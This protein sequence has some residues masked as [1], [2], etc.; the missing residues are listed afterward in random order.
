MI[1]EYDVMTDS[2]VEEEDGRVGPHTHLD[3]L[4][5][6]FFTSTLFLTDVALGL[7][8]LVGIATAIGLLLIGSQNW[9][10]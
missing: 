3:C 4:R 2:P 5:N 8:W 7:S 10:I 1:S 9:H 6:L